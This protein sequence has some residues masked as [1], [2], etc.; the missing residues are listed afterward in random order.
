M[1]LAALA[2]MLEEARGGVFFLPANPPAKAV[3]QAL[4]AAGLMR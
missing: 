4:K 2:G 1:T 3:Q